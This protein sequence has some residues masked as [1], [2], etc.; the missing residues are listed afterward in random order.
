MDA[1]TGPRVR[2]VGHATAVVDV[3]GVRVLT[4]PLL[5]PRTGPLL[6]HAEPLQEAWWEGVDVVLLSHL[7]HDHVDVPSLRSLPT[8]TRVLA[9]RGAA[10]VLARTGLRD[11]VEVVPGERV[12]VGAV[13]V[14]VVPARHDDRRWRGPWGAVARPVGYLVEGSTS[15]YFAGD[16][17]VFPEMSQLRGR[18]DVALLPVGGWGVTLGDGHLDPRRAAESLRVLAP[19]VAVPVHW[20]TLRPVGLRRVRPR[21]FDEPGPR[22]HRLAAEL[23]PDVEV[24]VLS[25][26]EAL[27]L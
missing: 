27:G 6:R 26:G 22:F 19:A 13:T 25:P 12:T 15:T 8:T 2:W 7:H 1:R 14:E 3:D 23:A 17:D 11:V 24:T 9:P 21:L 10:P 18:V 16:T 5:R 20:G 4:D